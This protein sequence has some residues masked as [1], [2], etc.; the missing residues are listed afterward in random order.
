M[1]KKYVI[2]NDFVTFICGD[3]IDNGGSST[4]Y[5]CYK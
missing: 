4:I 5:K 1:S 3:S 2:K